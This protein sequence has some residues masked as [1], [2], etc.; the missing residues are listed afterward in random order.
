[1]A[2]SNNKVKKI[3]YFFESGDHCIWAM[4]LIAKKMPN[5]MINSSEASSS[6]ANPMGRYLF[7]QSSLTDAERES[8]ASWVK[9]YGGRLA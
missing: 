8:I 3:R 1:M 4:Q 6:E 2:Q 7:V 9:A 5:I